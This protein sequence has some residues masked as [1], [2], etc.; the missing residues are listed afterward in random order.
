MK[1]DSDA[2]ILISKFEIKSK[3]QSSISFD[4]VNV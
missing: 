4:I 3:H 2:E 1:T